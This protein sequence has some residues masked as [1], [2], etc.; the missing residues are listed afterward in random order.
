MVLEGSHAVCVDPV[1]LVWVYEALIEEVLLEV[2][3][4]LSDIYNF[5]LL[6]KR[7]LSIVRVSHLV[8]GGAFGW[9]VSL[10]GLEILRELWNGEASR[11]LTTIW[12]GRKADLRVGADIQVTL[13][14]SWS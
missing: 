13:S 10:D 7:E 9:I 1:R 8:I 6:L 3:N 2:G 4:S 5:T 12:V 14:C 11:G